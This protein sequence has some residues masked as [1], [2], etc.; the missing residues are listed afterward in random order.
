MF[1]RECGKKIKEGV[2]FCGSC[3]TPVSKKGSSKPM[4]VGQ[5]DEHE[6]KKG[7][8]DKHEDRFERRE[9]ED[10]EEQKP[11]SK[12]DGPSHRC[13]VCNNKVEY[14]EKYQKYYCDRCRK[15]PFDEQAAQ[16]VPAMVRSLYASALI[17][18]LVGGILLLATDFGGWYVGGYLVR[19]WH[20]IS[21]FAS[22]L[23]GLAFF[24]VA[25]CL[26]LGSII[27]IMGLSP[28]KI[29]SRGLNWT[30]FIGALIV[31]IIVI[32]G[33]I[34]LFVFTEADDIWL[35]EG[36]YG[37]AIGSLL[38]TILF[39]MIIRNTTPTKRIIPPRY[40]PNQRS[41][42]RPHRP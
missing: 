34:S 38:T 14:V 39:W 33:G 37:G 28:S 30:G 27:S 23:M 31:F 42:G 9:R 41:Y 21:A 10:R 26:F 8:T 24:G 5:R 19:S 7:S 22:P 6:P 18:S 1:C 2:K 35:S 13:P 32:I 11:R 36:F 4:I 12:S 3:G 15:Y 29:P 40:P 17:T 16:Q 25:F 20:Y